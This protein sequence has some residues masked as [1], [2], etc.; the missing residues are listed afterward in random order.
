[1]VHTTPPALL[2]P[3]P[4]RNESSELSSISA[5]VTAVEPFPEGLRPS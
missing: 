2:P 5:G 4:T 3:I 1:M